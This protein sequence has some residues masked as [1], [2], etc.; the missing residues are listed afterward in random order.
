MKRTTER[1]INAQSRIHDTLDFDFPSLFILFFSSLPSFSSHVDGQKN[2]HLTCAPARSVDPGDIVE[3]R[4][5]PRVVDAHTDRTNDAAFDQYSRERARRLGQSCVFAEDRTRVR[6]CAAT[7]RAKAEEG[8]GRRH[9]NSS[10]AIARRATLDWSLQGSSSLSTDSR[11]VCF[12][13]ADWSS[14]LR[15]RPSIV[16][17]SICR[18]SCD[19]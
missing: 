18:R 4:I 6:S 2:R 13:V 12:R 10:V 1:R 5:A 9:G 3:P 7:S 8:A 11:Q 16:C 17:I 15:F 19:S 14:R